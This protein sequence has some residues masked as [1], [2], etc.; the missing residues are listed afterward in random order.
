M[1]RLLT[2]APVPVR[3]KVVAG[4]VS[5]ASGSDS[6]TAVPPPFLRASVE[7]EI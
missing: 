7:G 1:D 5:A 6:A 2:M 3:V 4:V